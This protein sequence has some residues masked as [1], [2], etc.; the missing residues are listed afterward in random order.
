MAGRPQK[1]SAAAP[2]E[3]REAFNSATKGFAI[4]GAAGRAENGPATASTVINARVAAFVSR[5]NELAARV[6]E[7]GKMIAG[8]RPSA[9]ADKEGLE[10][11]E[12]FWLMDPDENPVGNVHR[13]HDQD[14]GEVVGL[15][16]LLYG[17]PFPDSPGFRY[18]QLLAH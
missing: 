13:I 9:L 4:F 16:L 1:R 10:L 14:T 12:A 5:A 18:A 7:P 8:V 15:V 17:R 3:P 2:H 6:R 11:G